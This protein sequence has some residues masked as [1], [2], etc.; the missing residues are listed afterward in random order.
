MRTLP[1]KV[2]DTLLGVRQDIL[3]ASLKTVLVQTD[4]EPLDV[5]LKKLTS[6]ITTEAIVNGRIDYARLKDNV[7]YQD[8]RHLTQQ[9]A[10]F[11]ISSL[12]QHERKMAFW[13]NLYNALTIDGIIHYGISQRVTENLGFFRQAAY[14]VGGF[15][16][17][18]DDIEHGIL[19]ANAG[20]PFI[21]GSQFGKDDPRRAFVLAQAD[22]RIHFALVCGAISCP[23]IHFY[24]AENIDI[25]LNLAA[26]NFLEQNLEIDT[27]RSSIQLSK[28]LQWYPEDFGASAW[29]KLGIGDKTPLLQTIKPHI[30][31]EKKRAILEKSHQ[32]TIHFK[33]YN[34]ALNAV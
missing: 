4:D 32:M 22:Y 7:I 23:P 31:D 15:R 24:D 10:S 12:R 1:Q 16:F 5:R 17:C 6:R 27:Q 11:D 3:N 13:L 8:Y 20:H 34:W 14:C 19:R 28:I 18:L 25:Q 2:F 21:P 33:S 29:V 26:Q 9:L 30:M